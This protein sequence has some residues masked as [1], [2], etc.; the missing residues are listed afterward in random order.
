MLYLSLHT[1]NSLCAMYGHS[2]GRKVT[3]TVVS[4]FGSIFPSYSN[5]SLFFFFRN[6]STQISALR[7]QD[8]VRLVK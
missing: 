8:S 4:A 5:Y 7:Q 6:Q 2:N 3:S 1:K